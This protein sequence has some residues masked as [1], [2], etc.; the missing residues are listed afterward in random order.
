MSDE[1]SN[2]VSQE[3][4]SI[5]EGILSEPS[6]PLEY[7]T[8]PQSWK[9]EVAQRHWR[10]LDPD[11]RG[12]LHTREKEAGSK[13]SEQGKRLKDLEA[14]SQRVAELEGVSSRYQPIDGL[15]EQYKPHIPEGLE[16]AQAIASLLEAHR[17]LADPQTRPQ[18]MAQLFEAY[19]V[20]NPVEVLPQQYR[21]QFETAQS[22]LQKTREA[23]SLKAFNE[24]AEGKPYIQEIMPDIAAEMRT[25][26]QQAPGLDGRTLLR[27]AHDNVIERSGLKAR[28]DE[29][30]KAEQEGRTVQAQA[31]RLKE[32]AAQE[33]K[34]R[35]EQD[36]L[37]KAAK[38]A[39]GINVRSSPSTFSAPKTLD[40]ELRTIA[41]R[42]YRR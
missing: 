7:D 34:R 9:P 15:F 24:Y 39:A 12:Y 28:L 27:L 30:A 3:T 37:V 13:I 26:R 29:Q 35:E 18:A 10:A 2:D 23:E 32:M 20:Q 38:R 41:D 8:P 5:A 17:L 4:T 11:L 6:A 33:K 25:L 40:E 16:P 31:E 1:F 21:E 22:Q 42:A 14:T 19:G 36:R